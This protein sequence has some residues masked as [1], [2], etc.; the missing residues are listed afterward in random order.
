MMFMTVQAFCDVHGQPGIVRGMAQQA[1]H[2][3]IPTIR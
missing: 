3:R 2:A 1:G